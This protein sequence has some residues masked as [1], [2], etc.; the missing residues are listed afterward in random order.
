MSDTPIHSFIIQRI[1]I[2]CLLCARHSSRNWGY[3]REW[4]R[5]KSLASGSSYSS[6]RHFPWEFFWLDG[7]HWELYLVGHWI[8]LYSSKSHWTLS[9]TE[10]R[11]FLIVSDGRVNL[12]PVTLFGQ[13]PKFSSTGFF[14]FF[15]IRKSLGLGEARL[16]IP[17]VTYN[18]L[19]M[20][21]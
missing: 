2:A 18:F 17:S 11:Y 14:F 7:R 16:E 9:R 4:N 10:L 21:L 13:N 15:L 20:S 12:A 5:Y 6:P 3:G 19:W 8:C 1:V